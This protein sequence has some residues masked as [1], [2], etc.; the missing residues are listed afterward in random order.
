MR[1][2]DAP[3]LHAWLQ[4]LPDVNALFWGHA[5]GFFVAQ[6]YLLHVNP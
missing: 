2:S 5:D 6:L 1:A 4:Q 3:T